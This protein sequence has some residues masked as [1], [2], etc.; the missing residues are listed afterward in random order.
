MSTQTTTQSVTNSKIAIAAVAALAAGSMAFAAVPVQKNIASNQCQVASVVLR[1]SCGTGKGYKSAAVS[2]GNG[3]SEVVSAKTCV[4]ATNWNTQAQAIC[5]KSCKAIK[6]SV[7]LPN[8]DA[9]TARETAPTP[10]SVATS[11]AVV[12]TF[13]TPP[14]RSGRDFPGPHDLS[15]DAPIL[16]DRCG[17]PQGG[18]QRG[19]TYKLAGDVQLAPNSNYCFLVST[20]NV[21]LDCDGHSITGTGEGIGVS[22]SARFTEVRNC[23]INT[24]RDGVS[25]DS[26]LSSY[27]VVRLNTITNTSRHGIYLSRATFNDVVNN[28]IQQNSPTVNTVGITLAEGVGQNYLIGNSIT[29]GD[30]IYTSH[31]G[32]QISGERN[33]VLN[34]R[35]EG[36]ADEGITL[37]SR[38]EEN[39][40]VGNFVRGSRVGVAVR[41]DR[42]VN[43]I[44]GNTLCGN[45][46][47]DLWCPGFPENSQDS[48]KGTGNTI[49]NVS[50]ACPSNGWPMLNV[51]YTN[52]CR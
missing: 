16:L 22:L 8:V 46:I 41:D 39:W 15:T 2:C 5:T 3:Y 52:A 50:V 17:A 28:T 14:Q 32:I 21:L 34:N 49:G 40:V 23:H 42:R 4:S 19:H 1:D 30:S 44:S 13:S 45:T 20:E 26:P 11:T 27:A 36:L 10:T 12:E 29:F 7:Q 9:P 33:V 25:L 35:I 43:Y 37:G 6:E 47:T 48:I 38:L 51:N 24:V 31:Y 18:F